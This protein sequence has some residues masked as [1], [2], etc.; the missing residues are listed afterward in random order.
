MSNEIELTC[1]VLLTD[2]KKFL[3]VTRFGRREDI[4]DIPRM[5]IRAGNKLSFEDNAKIAIFNQTGLRVDDKITPVEEIGE[6]SLKEESIIKVF[7]IKY[8][9]LPPISEMK[10]HEFFSLVRKIEVRQARIENWSYVDFEDIE[11]YTA[12]IPGLDDVLK[13][14]YIHEKEGLS[15]NQIA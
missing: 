14:I 13:K 3:N 6:F 5:K 15:Y 11:N 2:G 7:K 8:R 1:A 12:S 4:L 9:N 10:C